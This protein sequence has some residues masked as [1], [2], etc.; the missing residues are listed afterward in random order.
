LGEV[1]KLTWMTTSLRDTLPWK[2]NLTNVRE[3]GEKRNLTKGMWF[4]A[5]QFCVIGK[6]AL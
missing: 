3:R 6:I 2:E 1:R 5:L 4:R